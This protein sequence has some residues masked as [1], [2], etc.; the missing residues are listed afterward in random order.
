MD[1]FLHVSF[2]RARDVILYLP[3]DRQT[4]STSGDREIHDINIDRL[5]FAAINLWYPQR[6]IPTLNLVIY[7]L[8][9]WNVYPINSN[10]Y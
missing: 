4:K 10:K 9:S 3:D 2:I 6:F 5:H 1:T 7:P 8:V